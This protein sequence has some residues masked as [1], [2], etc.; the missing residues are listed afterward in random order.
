MHLAPGTKLV[1]R[2]GRLRPLGFILFGL[3]VGLLGGGGVADGGVGGWFLVAVG[4]GLVGI[5]IWILCSGQMYLRLNPAGFSFGTL[6]GRFAYSWDDVAEFVAGEANGLG[7][8]LFCL[9][10]EEEAGRMD[11]PEPRVLPDTY[12]MK[13]ERLA[14]LLNDWRARYASRVSYTLPDGTNTAGSAM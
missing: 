10:G 9:V 2:V 12:G 3:L 11:G 6:M 4:V 13:A 14:S 1:L 7:C 8:V 5:G